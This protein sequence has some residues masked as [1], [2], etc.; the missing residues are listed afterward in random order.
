VKL[1][2]MLNVK[3]HEVLVKWTW[4]RT[5]WTLYI[6]DVQEVLS[7]DACVNRYISGPAMDWKA[8]GFDDDSAERQHEH[9]FQ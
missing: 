6:S 2:I 4:A 7:I 9:P 8:A 5:F 3:N 1:V